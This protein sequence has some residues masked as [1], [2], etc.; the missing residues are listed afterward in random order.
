[1]GV[2]FTR[3]KTPGDIYEQ[4]HAR[5]GPYSLA[6]VWATELSFGANRSIR[7]DLADEDIESSGMGKWFPGWTGGGSPPSGAGEGSGGGTPER[8]RRTWLWV[9]EPPRSLQGKVPEWFRGG[10]YRP[11]DRRSFSCMGGFGGQEPPEEAQGMVRGE[12]L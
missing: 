10:R 5:C 3:N 11:P 1:M 7:C 4:K 9:S 12:P 2:N 8:P 6:R